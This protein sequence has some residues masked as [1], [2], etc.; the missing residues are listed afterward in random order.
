MTGWI[1]VVPVRRFAAAKSRLEV[2]DREGVARA[3]ALDTLQVLTSVPAVRRVLVITDDPGERSWP[4]AMRAVQQRRRGLSGAV[5]DGIAAARLLD[6]RGPVAVVLGDLPRI[7][8]TAV[9]A[10]LA[11]AA[12]V[13]VGFVR[14]AAGTGTTTV[15]IAPGVRFATAFGRD[16]AA[17]HRALGAVELTA[18]VALRHDL[19]TA[20]DLA[21]AH[22]SSGP[23]LAA[24]LEAH[25]P[26]R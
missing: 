10:L 24:L 5:A 20:A 26:G 22:G 9:T 12:R 4:D 14:D 7:T 19:D 1:V 13:P 18:S 23:C 25:P 3:V 15:T 11:A 2:P 17:H 16:S 21:R 6:P 8:P